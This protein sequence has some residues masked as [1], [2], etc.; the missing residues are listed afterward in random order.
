L[1]WGHN[2]APS[3][4]GFMAEYAHPRDSLKRSIAETILPR[5]QRQFRNQ[6]TSQ[7]KMI[8]YRQ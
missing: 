5:V 3:I 2:A 8:E 6:T 1:I 4:I 7:G